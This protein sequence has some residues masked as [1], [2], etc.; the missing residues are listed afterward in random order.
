MPTL[1]V[2]RFGD[3]VRLAVH[4]TER[5]PKTAGSGIIWFHPETDAALPY[6]ASITVY[7]Q[8]R[9]RVYDSI[10]KSSRRRFD[11]WKH[12]QKWIGEEYCKLREAQ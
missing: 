4:I 2:T 6:R 12:A 7:K 8:I 11:D 1:H 5:S 9:P 10:G 3:G